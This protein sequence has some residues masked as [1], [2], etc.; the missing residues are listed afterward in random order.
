MIHDNIKCT[1]KPDAGKMSG[2]MIHIHIL[3][4]NCEEQFTNIKAGF[5]QFIKHMGKNFD[6]GTNIEK[7]ITQIEQYLL[8]TDIIP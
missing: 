5:K 2:R 3:K 7:E 1:F 4:T 6:T 8:K